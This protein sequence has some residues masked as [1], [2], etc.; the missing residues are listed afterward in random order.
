MYPYHI[1]T[2]SAHLLQLTT[3]KAPSPTT[4]LQVH[5]PPSL[6]LFSNSFFFL[7]VDYLKDENAFLSRVEADATSFKPLGN[8]IYSYTRPVP[9]VAGKGKGI[10][11]SEG[12]DPE[13]EDTVVFEV[14]HVS[15]I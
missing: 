3:W 13:S 1:P 15:Q 11:R 8:L 10:V 5:T 12:L 6:L 4:F 7:R 9:G 14:Y 2:S